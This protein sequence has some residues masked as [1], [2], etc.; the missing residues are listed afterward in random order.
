MYVQAVHANVSLTIFAPKMPFRPV[1]M[2]TLIGGTK[3]LSTFSALMDVTDTALAEDG[4]TCVTGNICFF[5]GK[6]ASTNADF[7]Y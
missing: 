5:P 1:P 3:R 6:K 2:S 7:A 4:R